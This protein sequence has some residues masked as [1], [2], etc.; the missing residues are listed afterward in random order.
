MHL[1]IYTFPAVH[2]SLFTVTVSVSEFEVYCQ[3]RP[4]SFKISYRGLLSFILFQLFY[5]GALF[6]GQDRAVCLFVCFGVL[7]SLLATRL[8]HGRYPI[9][10][11][12]NFA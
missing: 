2:N 1:H 8:S 4:S 5:L 10:T 12:D 3:N 6:V 9:L 7:T 11:S